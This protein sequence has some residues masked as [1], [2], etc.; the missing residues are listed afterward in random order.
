MTGPSDTANTALPVA[1]GADTRREIWRSSRGHRLALLAVGVLGVAGATAGLVGPAVIGRLVDRVEAGTATVGTV[2]WAAAIMIG[3]ALLGAIGTAVTIVLAGRSYHT[4]LADLRERLVGCALQLPQGVV[5]RA[6]TGDLISRSSDDVAEVADAAPRIIPAFTSVAFTIIVTFAGMTAL[7]WWYGLT[8]VIVLPVY[9]I[10]VRWYLRTGPRIYRAERTAMSHRAQQLLESQRGYETVLSFGLGDL[11]H[12]SVLN[13]S[14]SVVAHTLRA[15]TVQ[16]MFFGRLN[17]AEYLGMSAIL[18]AGF[19]LIGTGQ[20]TVGAAT[21]AM[22]LFLR[23]FGPINQLLFVI[24]VLQSVLASLSRMVGVITFAP[25]EATPNAS[26]GALPNASSRQVGVQLE[27]VTF[28]YNGEHPALDGI[29]LLVRPGERIAVVGASGAGKTT[30]ATVIAGIHLPQ[31]GTVVRP[32]D[33]AM[34]TQE[35]H[36]FAGS[37]RDNLTLARPEATDD[38]VHQALTTTGAQT[39]LDLLP[40][41]LDTI[42]GTTG[43][44]LTAAQ[45]QQIALARLVLADPDLAILDE[46]T[47][48]AGST[49]AHVLDHAADAALQGRTGLVIAH[50]LTQAATCDR[51]VVMDHGRITETGTH[52]ELLR[53][54][55]TYARLWHTWNARRDDRPAS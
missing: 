9:V 13:A 54:G 14:W 25:T 6:G 5:E 1:T 29:D 39:L 49:H 21:A 17:L 40:D 3:A 34:I 10:T 26:N 7:D 2:A 48:E 38:Q 23:L 28:S 4:M 18:L 44:S 52:T 46:A 16:N 45:T 53:S 32:D 15:R 43:H 19:W 37:L 50:R 31:V 33:T 30:L 22:L 8:M 55:G 42:L 12:R 27:Q 36:V 24:D 20:S 51:I 47:A 35:G 41:G 11:R